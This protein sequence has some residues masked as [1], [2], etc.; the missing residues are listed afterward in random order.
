MAG[1]AN[2]SKKRQEG[3]YGDRDPRTK[4]SYS[5]TQD[6][7]PIQ[8]IDAWADQILFWRTHLD[9]FLEDYFSCPNQPLKFY[10]FQKL[11]IRDMG[12]QNYVFDDES[13]GLGKTWKLAW[14]AIGMCTLYPKNSIAVIAPTAQQAV[15]VIEKIKEIYDENEVVRR[16]IKDEPRISRDI[17]RVEFM[18]GSY[19]IAR[20]H[21]K[22]GQ[23]VRGG[24]FKILIL[25]EAMLLY[26]NIMG[27]IRP[28]LNHVRPAVMNIRVTKNM[29]DYPDIQSKVIECTSAF[30]KF[31]DHFKRLK[32]SYISMLRRENASVFGLSYHFGIKYRLFDENFIEEE[33][34]RYSKEVFDMEYGCR[35]IG[36]SENGFY[37]YE[38]IMAVRTLRRVELFQPKKTTSKYIISC[39]IATGKRDTSDNACIGIIKYTEQQNGHFDKRLVFA[40][41]YHGN[42]LAEIALEIRR[43]HAA[44]PNTKKIIVDI[45]GL[46]E[47]IPPLLQTPYFDEEL[48]AE[49]PPLVEIGTL[50]ASGNGSLPIVQSY[51]GDNESN[52]RGAMAIKLFMENKTLSLPAP[53]VSIKD[54]ISEGRRLSRDLL[55]EEMAI[56]S[57][58]DAL[59]FELMNIRQVK[60]VNSI[61]YDVRK[62][63]HKDR[64]SMLMMA[65]LD[66]YDQEVKTRKENVRRS[67]GSRISAVNVTWG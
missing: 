36:T 5:V 58:C 66:L 61:R 7:L 45:N 18:N 13:R 67:G 63:K 55:L 12:N 60:T 26:D 53:S 43:L 56:Y 44:F 62:G 17:G 50:M 20:A 65:C 19:I 28:S 52:N 15:R 24:R 38:G 49:L 3:I 16:E 23:S 39:D 33:R 37:G 46:G 29:P 41:T 27:G 22:D 47:G 34:A 21:G 48:G 59:M 10:P 14:F 57:D 64:Y 2:F 11:V 51:R 25:D 4:E 42:T 8:N 30:Y 9:I 35:H 32:T 1:Y 31:A 40:R 54:T 6:E